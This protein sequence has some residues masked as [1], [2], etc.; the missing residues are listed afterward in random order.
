MG[1][2]SARP[3]TELSYPILTLPGCVPLPTQTIRTVVGRGERQAALRAARRS[4]RT[5]V[6]A[7]QGADGEIRPVGCLARLLSIRN[8]AD[9]SV[10]PVLRS[11][12]RVRLTGIER[13]GDARFAAVRPLPEPCAAAERSEPLRD[14]LV[15]CCRTLAVEL[16][17][18]E[19]ATDLEILIGAVA[20]QLSWPTATAYDLL[21]AE[22]TAR[23]GERLLA[24][25]RRRIDAEQEADR[26]PLPSAPHPEAACRRRYAQRRLRRLLGAVVPPGEPSCSRFRRRA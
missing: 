6:L 8:A 17:A 4:G 14:A 18:S 5:V 15:R 25:L 26:V 20:Q 3:P 24:L 1:S 10:R 23:R 19:R 22:G 9:G 12:T 16:T 2:P 13:K 11:G 7:V 21:A